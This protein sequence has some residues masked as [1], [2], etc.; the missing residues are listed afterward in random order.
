MFPQPAQIVTLLDSA[1]NGAGRVD[2]LIAFSRTTSDV[3]YT[4]HDGEYNALVEL[5]NERGRIIDNIHKT[6][7]FNFRE[8]RRCRPSWTPLA[9]GYLRRFVIGSSIE[10]QNAPILINT[11][12]VRIAARSPNRPRSVDCG[13]ED[14]PDPISPE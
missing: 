3:G 13:I 8:L 4:L 11:G 14:S 5:L 12:V 6:L 10:P 7:D 9:T 2:P 1:Q